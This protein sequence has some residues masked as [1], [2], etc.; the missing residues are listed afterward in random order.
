MVETI[1]PERLHFACVCESH[2]V[3]VPLTP[4]PES[5]QFKRKVG[6]RYVD[7]Q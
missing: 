2:R 5:S 6:P 4:K 1:A 3:A 7:D